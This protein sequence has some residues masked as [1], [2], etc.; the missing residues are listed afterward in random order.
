MDDL[1]KSAFLDLVLSNKLLADAKHVEA[2]MRDMLVASVEKVE[3]GQ[4][5]H[6]ELREEIHALGA[7][8]ARAAQH[9]E[10]L[11]DVLANV[12]EDDVNV[13]AAID[14]HLAEVAQLEE[15]RKEEARTA[16]EARNTAKAVKDEE[17]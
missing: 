12:Y 9:I 16:R 6:Q 14:S 11:T 15:K 3:S 17:P 4:K 10:T 1:R 8:T 7:V 5:K 13:N 2:Q